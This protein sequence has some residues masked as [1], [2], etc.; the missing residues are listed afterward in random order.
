MKNTIQI[1][2]SADKLGGCAT[3]L[4]V[5]RMC[6]AM[7]RDGWNVTAVTRSGSPWRFDD[8]GQRASFDAAFKQNVERIGI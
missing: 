3:M 8:Q 1:E 7:R 5:E 6:Q 2:I 4:H